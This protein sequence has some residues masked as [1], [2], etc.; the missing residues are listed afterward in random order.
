MSISTCHQPFSL[1]PVS[2]F[3]ARCQP[4]WTLEH[5]IQRLVLL[6]LRLPSTVHTHVAART[7]SPRPPGTSSSSSPQRGP[8]TTTTT[9]ANPPSLNPPSAIPPIHLPVSPVHPAASCHLYSSLFAHRLFPVPDRLRLQH[10]S[11]STV[12]SL[13]HSYLLPVR[14]PSLSTLPPIQ[15]LPLSPCPTLLL[16]PQN[17]PA[18]LLLDSPLHTIIIITT[19]TSAPP[20]RLG[21]PC[22]V[23]LVVSI[24]VIFPL[25]GGVVCPLSRISSR[26]SLT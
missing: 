1:L 7:P 4:D 11:R 15:S 21:R 3:N 2:R 14:Q 22:Q 25:G 26:R 18:A 6:F 19:T 20:V 13:P 10:Q 9:F 24:Y 8:L 17:R 16:E 23:A 5:N 12:R